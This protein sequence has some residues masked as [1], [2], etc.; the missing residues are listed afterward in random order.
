[1][2]QKHQYNEYLDNII[3][4]NLYNIKSKHKLKSLLSS[5]CLLKQLSHV[6]CLNPR[7]MVFLNVFTVYMPVW[8]RTH[9]CQLLANSNF[10]Q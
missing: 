9:L 1:M 8:I 5:Q 6:H 3:Y 2:K 4:K 7:D 10:R